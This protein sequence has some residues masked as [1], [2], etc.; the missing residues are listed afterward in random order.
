M[1]YYAVIGNNSITITTTITITKQHCQAHQGH[2]PQ[3]HHPATIHRN[4]VVP[5]SMAIDEEVR[6][7]MNR[8]GGAAA[9]AQPWLPLELCRELERK[10]YFA[11]SSSSTLLVVLLVV[12]QRCCRQ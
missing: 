12:I 3:R 2:L 6:R 10:Q 4:E 7:A 9:A 1:Q 5:Q 8:P 11:G